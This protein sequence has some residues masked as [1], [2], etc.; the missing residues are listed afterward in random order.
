M[1][2]GPKTLAG[3]VT[4]RAPIP[5]VP[6]LSQGGAPKQTLAGIITRRA[7]TRTPVPTPVAL[8]NGGPLSYAGIVIWWAPLN[9]GLAR[10]ALSQGGAQ[11]LLD[12][13]HHHKAKP[14]TC[15]RTH[16][17]SIKL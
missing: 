8:N 3:I 5:I 1:R 16:A 15:T 9:L 11:N 6:A 13:R 2:W 4:R 14:Y 7:P 17:G 12:G 10:P